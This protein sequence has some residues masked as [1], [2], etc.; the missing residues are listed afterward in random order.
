MNQPALRWFS[1][2]GATAHVNGP[3]LPGRA[4]GLSLVNFNLLP[5]ATSSS[6]LH[7]SMAIYALFNAFYYHVSSS[8]G[9]REA[10][11]IV[12]AIV[13]VVLAVV[14]FILEGA[15][16]KQDMSFYTGHS[17][18]IFLWCIYSLLAALH[19]LV[20]FGKLKPCVGIAPTIMHPLANF[21]MS[22]ILFMGD[23]KF[24][25]GQ[26][27]DGYASG[28]KN[29]AALS[30]MAPSCYLPMPKPPCQKSL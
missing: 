24:L 6:I 13:Y 8:L 28:T 3:F 11:N 14:G 7:V 4:L 16:Y 18:H 9:R 29:M 25:D 15:T 17:K 26:H 30:N 22:L 19:F 2:D 27:P 12:A 20:Y 23:Y 10:I 1:G 21:F 5:S